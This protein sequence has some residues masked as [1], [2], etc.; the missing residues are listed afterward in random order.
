MEKG[1]MTEGNIWKQLILFSI[2]L[3]LGNLFQQLYNAVDS[4]I[5]GQFVSSQALA[6]VGS[7]FPLINLLISFFMGLSLGAGVVVS[8]YF[9]ARDIDNMRKSIHSSIVITFIIGVIMT[10]VGILACPIILRWMQTP[11]D[12]INDSIVYLQFYFGGILFTMIYNIGSGILRAV[13]DT[14]RPL[15]FLIICSIINIILDLLF[16]IFF[17]MGIAGAAYATVISQAISAI[18]TMLLLINTSNEYKISFKELKLYREQTKEIIRVG[19]P[20][21]IQNAVVA[22]SNVI[23]QSNINSFDWVAMAGCSACQ[24]LDGFAIMPVLSFSMAFTTFTG[25]NI[26]AKRYD[27]VKQGAKI[28]LIL[29]LSTIICISATLLYF[30]E[31]LLSIF[32]D[33]PEVIKYGL[34]MMHTLIPMYF[35]LTITHALNGIIRGAGKTKVPMLV[36]IVCWCCMRMAW[37]LTTVPLFND[38]QFVFYGWP[39]TWAASSLWLIIYYCSH[40]WLPEAYQK[41]S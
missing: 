30:D 20:S 37:I 11:S 33:D 38:I 7:S 9:G 13:G 22:I 26:G 19:I 21:G 41:Q 18:L 6:A 35:L 31:Q 8:K 5:V 36:M 40:K 28:G 34:M 25:Q 32:S 29:S 1:L 23:V 4:V 24:K 12:V 14:K 17:K 16:I 10:F 39:I 3:L 15:Y 27:R 2:P